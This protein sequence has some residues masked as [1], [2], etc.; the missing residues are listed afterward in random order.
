[1]KYKTDGAQNSYNSKKVSKAKYKISDFS[2]SLIWLQ[3]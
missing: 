2:Q 1:L 3:F